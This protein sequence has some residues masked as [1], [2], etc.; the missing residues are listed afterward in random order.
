MKKI[1]IIILLIILP[2]V[3]AEEVY[4]YG[5]SIDAIENYMDDAGTYND[6]L[7]TSKGDTVVKYGLIEN[8]E[9]ELKLEYRNNFK[10]GAQINKIEFSLSGKRSYLKIGKSFWTMTKDETNENMYV[11]EY[12]K[13][14]KSREKSATFGVRVTEYVQS[15][16]KV[17]GM[18]TLSSPWVFIPL[19]FERPDVTI[20]D[21]SRDKGLKI[22]NG[23]SQSKIAK[24]QVKD[25][26][27]KIKRKQEVAYTWIPEN[28]N[29]P[30]GNYDEYKELPNRKTA[31][32]IVNINT[33]NK[34]G[35]T[36]GYKLCVKEGIRD[37]YGNTSVTTKSEETYY[38][39]NTGPVMENVDINQNTNNQDDGLKAVK[40]RIYP[41]LKITMSDEHVKEVESMEVES[42]QLG[43][44][45]EKSDN[46][47]VSYTGEY[48]VKV[49]EFSEL[50]EDGKKTLTI[51]WADALGNE[52]EF[53]SPEVECKKWKTCRHPSHGC[54]APQSCRNEAYF[55][56]Q[57]LA[58]HKE[59]VAYKPT[60]RCCSNGTN[61]GNCYDTDNPS[62][63]WTGGDFCSVSG[64][65]CSRTET[66]TDGCAV[67]NVGVGSPPCGCDRY[68]NSESAACGCQELAVINN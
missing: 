14:I 36:G 6:Y 39:D 25:E 38:F 50:G 60:Y 63:G 30:S 47:K 9:K 17:L 64:Q 56:C 18:G 40:D 54:E 62:K 33:S 10:I 34:G 13:N 57:T 16:T 8:E 44:L 23:Y 55:G 20:N 32:Q 26:E 29:C 11:I 4:N 52:K 22:V 21:V 41:R 28:E 45:T 37:V 15:D 68:Y 24:I 42:T 61:S 65:K 49:D 19:D 48:T 35:F 2:V 51:I 46:G 59:C 43:Q 3:K 12:G 5:D 53:K 1:F 67:A 66:V 31:V 27:T 7:L 58:T